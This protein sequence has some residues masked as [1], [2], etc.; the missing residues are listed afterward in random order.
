MAH[1][2]PFNLNLRLALSLPFLTVLISCSEPAS[3]ETVNKYGEVALRVAQMLES[4]HYTRRPFGNEMSAKVLDT[5]LDVLDFRRVYFTQ[6]DIDSFNARFRSK[7]D[8]QILEKSIP[9]AGDIYGVYIDRVRARVE[10]AE[11][12]LTSETFTFESDRTVRITRKD[13]P[14]PKDTTEQKQIWRNII[15]EELLRDALSAELEAESAKKKGK[16]PKERKDPKERILKRY[17]DFLKTIIE[18]DTVEVATLFIKAVA[19]AY[20]PHSEYYSPRQFENFKIGMNK[21]LKGIGAM[22]RLDE[23]EVPT[24]EGIVTGGP[25]A[26]QGQ[27]KNLDKIV[28]VGQGEGEIVDVVGKKLSDTVDLIRGD[29]GTTVTLRVQPASADDPSETTLIKIVRDQVDLKDSLATADLI[30]TKDPEG[31]T[32]KLGWLRLPSFYSDMDGGDTSTTSDVRSLLTRL[33]IEGMDGLVVDLRDNGGGSLEEAVNMTGLFLHK[34]PIVQARNWR[35]QRTEKVSRNAKPVYRG[36]LIVLTNRASASASEIFAAALQDYNRAIIVGEKSTFGKGTVQQLRPVSS[37]RLNIFNR[38]NEEKGALK[39]TIQTFFRVNGD[40]TQL[41]GVI[42]D[43]QLPSI[44]DVEEFGEGSLKNPL[45]ADPIEP[46]DYRRFSSEPLP[47]E[48]LR[49]SMEPRIAASKDF[50]YIIEDIGEDKER[51]EKNQ[52]S[53]NKEKRKSEREE[54]KEESEARKE[55]RIARYEKM[56]A[57]EKDLFVVYT[58]TQ[59]NYAKR[60]LVLK[61]EISDEDLHGMSRAKHKEDEDDDAKL[62]EYPHLLDPYERE[63]IRILQDFIAIKETGKPVNFSK[64]APGKR[65]ALTPIPNAV[66]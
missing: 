53:L 55:E 59:K 21:K 41:K 47:I 19:R 5:Y 61:S 58:L 14:W 51:K 20:D 8:D 35:G 36:P 27:L 56:R 60:D 1:T 63:T 25:A 24:V 28:G 44:Y 29:I 16:E 30:I 17:N 2:S 15:E 49:Q 7:I 34:G 37:N 42:P 65:D 43:L 32:Q 48:A 13:A 9:A 57:D 54:N 10:Y 3:G 40:S 11:K 66:E 38:G 18:N 31:K 6:K 26:K 64:V 46:A 4:D 12:V 23:D 50:S 52:I 62:L 39:L 22:L 45:E 33:R